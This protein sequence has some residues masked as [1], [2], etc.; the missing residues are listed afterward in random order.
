MRKDT[1][2]RRKIGILTFLLYYVLKYVSKNRDAHFPVK[3]AMRV[4]SSMP[5]APGKQIQIL[6][7]SGLLFVV[8]VSDNSVNLITEITSVDIKEKIFQSKDTTHTPEDNFIVNLVSQIK[9]I[10]FKFPTGDKPSSHPAEA[11]EEMIEEIKRRQ[12]ERLK[13]IQKNRAKLRSDSPSNP[14]ISLFGEV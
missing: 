12:V 6:D 8:G 11:E 4:L 2:P 14:D 3:G 9:N 7:V 13:S 1:D 5:I 10:H